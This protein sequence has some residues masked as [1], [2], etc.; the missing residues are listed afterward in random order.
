M[1]A[2]FLVADVALIEPRLR[3]HR[4][5]EA[6][7]QIVCDHDIVAII[8]LV[9]PV[10]SWHAT[11]KHYQMT[12]GMLIANLFCRNLPAGKPTQYADA[13]KAIFSTVADEGKRT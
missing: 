5:P 1:V 9:S 8:D 10:E 4:S 3:M 2:E 13:K 11:L 7:L 12:V 6:C